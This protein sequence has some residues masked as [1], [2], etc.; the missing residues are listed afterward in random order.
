MGQFA[1]LMTIRYPNWDNDNKYQTR[2]DTLDDDDDDTFVSW[3]IQNVNAF[4]QEENIFYEYDSYSDFL[5]EYYPHD[6]EYATPPIRVSYY[7]I[8]ERKWH[9]LLDE[10]IEKIMDNWNHPNDISFEDEAQLI[11]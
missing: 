3:I 4:F 1:V 2:T 6:E 10:F 7:D 11:F 8:S 5:E 9:Y